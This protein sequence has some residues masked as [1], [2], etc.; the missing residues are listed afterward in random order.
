MTIPSAAPA[1]RHRRLG[2]TLLELAVV[3]CVVA[4]LASVGLERLLRY[5][6]LAEKAAMENAASV[7]RS[8]LGLRFAALYLDGNVGEIDRLA[9]ENPMDWLAQ[10]PP[11]YLG[12]LW[13]P[14]L[15][16]LPK[17]SWYYDKMTNLL[18]YYP[19]RTAHLERPDPKD[20]RIRFKVAVDF[21]QAGGSGRRQLSS[22]GIEPVQ[23]YAWFVDDGSG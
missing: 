1:S 21:G 5:Q 12:V 2:F 6:E 4:L 3:V 14:P 7:M 9:Q 18:V 23:P 15:E 19:D 22:L 16:S 17:G 8:A 20:P 10:R 11:N 13:S